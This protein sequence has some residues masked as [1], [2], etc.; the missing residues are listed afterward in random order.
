ML[1]RSSSI[2]FTY[3]SLESCNILRGMW[4]M[5]GVRYDILS[6]LWIIHVTFHITFTTRKVNLWTLWH[7]RYNFLLYYLIIEF[8]FTAL[9]YTHYLVHYLVKRYLKLIFFSRKILCMFLI[10]FDTERIV[11]TYISL[12]CNTILTIQKSCHSLKL[13]H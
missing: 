6:E 7:F 5:N 4:L 10:C 2:I 8:G 3:S 9:L 1:E 11:Q 13:C 12:F